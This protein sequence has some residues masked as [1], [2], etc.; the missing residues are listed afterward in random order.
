MSFMLQMCSCGRG[1]VYALGLCHRC[2]RVR[3]RD[4][5]S[6]PIEHGVLSGYTTRGCRCSLCRKAMT[7]YAAEYR[8][9]KQAES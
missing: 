3:W 6:A 1:T 2:Y 7:S 8:A 5:T 4:T 9:K